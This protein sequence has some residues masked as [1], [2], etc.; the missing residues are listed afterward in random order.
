MRSR[1]CL[2]LVLLLLA[3]VPA[4]PQSKRGPA[5]SEERDATV[6]AARLLETD[7]F[8][9]DARKIREAVLMFLIEVPD[10]HIEA[11]MGWLGP[12]GGSK[13]DKEMEL[14]IQ[15]MISSASFI[16]RNPDQ[17][18]DRVAVALGGL[19]GALRRYEAILLKKPKSRHEFLDGLI[20]KRE[21]GELRAYVEEIAKTKCTG[22]S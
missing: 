16:I 21:K 9:K 8:H 10:I 20:A 3:A 1:I 19:E 2:F 17:A 7:P 12:L 11:C 13:A 4:L 15:T 14:F 6:K 18:S 5:T 22:K